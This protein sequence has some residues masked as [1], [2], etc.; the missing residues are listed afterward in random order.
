MFWFSLAANAEPALGSADAPVTIVEYGSLTCDYCVRF[1]REVLPLIRSRH[2]D[3]GRVRFIYRDFPTSM[4][5]I[6]GAVAARCA[7]D[8]YYTML[9]ALYVSVGSWSR[10]LDVDAALIQQ[11][12]SLGVDK[13]TFR[14]CLD[15]P[16]HERAI[17][18]EQRRATTEYGVTGTPTFLINDKIVRGVKAIDEMEALIE[19]A[20]PHPSQSSAERT[21]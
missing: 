17:D 5:A 2:I 3:T 10:T 15:D 4:A 1:H 18:D 6:R 20:L 16:Q 7:A 19:D 14:A 21:K 8:D 11:A 13:E 9:D 12:A